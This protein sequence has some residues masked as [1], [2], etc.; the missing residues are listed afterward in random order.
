MI[1]SRPE[2]FL[3]DK[4]S[5]SKRIKALLQLQVPTRS[6]WVREYLEGSYGMSSSLI[7][8]FPPR[9]KQPNWKMVLRSLGDAGYQIGLAEERNPLQ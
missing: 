6:F 9:W 3:P 2:A 7:Q 4:K 5:P 8:P 1:D